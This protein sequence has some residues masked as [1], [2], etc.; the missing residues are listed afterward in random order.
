MRA[1]EQQIAALAA[2]LGMPASQA[3]T[4]G[5]AAAAAVRDPA[6]QPQPTEALARG[7]PAVG[8]SGGAVI[9]QPWDVFQQQQAQQAAAQRQAALQQLQPR[10]PQ[11]QE[12]EHGWE[13]E[14]AAAAEV[15]A[16]Q[17]A[18]EVVAACWAGSAQQ[19]AA[20]QGREQQ[21]GLGQEGRPVLKRDRSKVYAPSAKRQERPGSG[22][23]WAKDPQPASSGGSSMQMSAASEGGTPRAHGEA[24][25]AS[26]GG[27]EDG[28][29]PHQRR[30]IMQRTKA[31]LQLWKALR[32]RV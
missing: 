16:Q 19:L 29:D 3:P 17:P 14:L 2:A 21:Q 18:V 22:G 31:A 11:Q 13:A 28:L 6:A 9:G 24:A 1:A 10:L 20:G 4:A 15:A 25:P 30:T 23:M 5:A 32:V 12:W 8:E 26:G 27:G 7:S